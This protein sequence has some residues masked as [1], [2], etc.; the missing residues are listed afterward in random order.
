MA[1]GRRNRAG[2]GSVARTRGAT[3]TGEMKYFDFTVGVTALAAVTTTW[4]SGTQMSTNMVSIDLGDPALATTTMFVPKVSAA[5]NG[6]IGRK[7]KLLKI[8]FQGAINVPPQNAQAAADSPTEVRIA[9]VHDKQ[10]NGALM[11]GAQLFNDCTSTGLGTLNSYQNPNNFGRFQVLKDKRFSISNLNMTG[12]PTTAD[13]VQ[14]GITKPFKFSHV[15][16]KPITVNF[17]AT[18]GGTIADVIDHSFHIIAGVN[19]AAYAPTLTCYGRCSY[20]D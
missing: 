19:S 11:S 10:T 16:K 1:R 14:A 4:V 3:V 7:V 6:R 2:F 18:N 17:N 13:C 15:F 20:K 9:F 12:S 8:K 5:L